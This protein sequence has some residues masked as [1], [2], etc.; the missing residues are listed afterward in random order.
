VEG[1]ERFVV[2][3]IVD[4]VKNPDEGILNCVTEKLADIVDR[5]V[6]REL[7]ADAGWMLVE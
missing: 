2:V 4:L 6:S 5:R 1:F 7:L 3:N